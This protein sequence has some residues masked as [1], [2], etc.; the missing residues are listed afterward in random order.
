MSIVFSEFP[1]DR[2]FRE[3]PGCP[4]TG[5]WTKRRSFPGLRGPVGRGPPLYEA[6]I[7]AAGDEMSNLPLAMGTGKI[8]WD[9]IYDQPSVSRI[10]P[11]GVSRFDKRG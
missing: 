7:A 10:D 2:I 1:A 3:P 8:V 5:Q 11:A 4:A 6:L 9:M